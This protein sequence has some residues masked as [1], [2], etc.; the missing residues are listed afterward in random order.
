MVI[1]MKV[2]EKKNERILLEI[3]DGSHLSLN[4]IHLLKSEKCSILRSAH[5][6]NLDVQTLF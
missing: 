1:M 4:D 3:K 6:G 5:V 2:L